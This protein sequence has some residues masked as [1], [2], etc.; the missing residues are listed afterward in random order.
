[1]ST[2]VTIRPYTLWNLLDNFIIQLGVEGDNICNNR[3]SE[4]RFYNTLVNLIC[5]QESVKLLDNLVIEKPFYPYI[6]LT[7]YVL[8]FKGDFGL[9][10]ALYNKLS[11]IR[12]RYSRLFDENEETSLKILEKVIT[13]FDALNKSDKNNHKNML[14]HHLEILMNM[15][16]DAQCIEHD[17]SCL[18]RDLI[19]SHLDINV[20]QIRKVYKDI[21][22][23]CATEL[24]PID[25]ELIEGYNLFIDK[26]FKPI[27]MFLLGVADRRLRAIEHIYD[28]L[29]DLESEKKLLEEWLNTIQQLQKKLRI[30][31]ENVRVIMY[32]LSP[33]LSSLIFYLLITLHIA[34]I[35]DW[36][37]WIISLSPLVIYVPKIIEKILK[38][39][40]KKIEKKIIHLKSSE[41]E[42]LANIIWS[43]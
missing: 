12:E 8:F 40:I 42:R 6:L 30:Y 7:Y 39:E 36:L 19:V 17:W 33:L 16:K 34:T 2:V 23:V 9:A 41:I 37:T 38:Q 35:T 43:S 3:T 11:D 32:I 26:S 13:F 22:R 25:E 5:I 28:K 10:K 14:R 29:Y 18:F 15:L 21:T 24:E 4:D 31:V 20:E 27:C 1:M